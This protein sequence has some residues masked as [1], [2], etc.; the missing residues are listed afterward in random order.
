MGSAGRFFVLEGNRNLRERLS[1]EC[2]ACG[3]NGAT[4]MSGWWQMAKGMWIKPAKA[5]GKRGKAGV[6]KMRCKT[7]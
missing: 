6:L 2:L 5:L 1:N 7:Q 3:G 4:R